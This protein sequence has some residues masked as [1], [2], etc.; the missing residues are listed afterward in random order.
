MSLQDYPDLYHA[1]LAKVDMRLLT[2]FS[3]YILENG[4]DAYSNFSLTVKKALK[5]ALIICYARPFIDNKDE[6]GEANT[7]FLDRLIKDYDSEERVIHDTVLEMRKT[8]I[9]DFD[10]STNDLKNFDP[11]IVH[12]AMSTN[13]EKPLEF[14]IVETLKRMSDKINSAANELA[15]D[16]LN[17]DA[18]VV[19]RVMN[20]V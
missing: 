12:I 9:G 19:M 2:H 15:D 1:Y 20:E 8:E 3:D 4:S 11:N 13:I 17:Q 14:S 5:I 16:T 6:N 10:I 18:G 7:D